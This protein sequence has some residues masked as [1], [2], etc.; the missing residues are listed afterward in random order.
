M[1]AP[2]PKFLLPFRRKGVFPN[3]T[4]EILIKLNKIDMVGLR[5]WSYYD[6]EECDLYPA[7]RKAVGWEFKIDIMLSTLKSKINHGL[8]KCMNLINEKTK[9]YTNRNIDE[10]GVNYIASYS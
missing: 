8:E 9:S 6:Y 4:N 2:N 7:I 1:H 3:L 5:Y 10:A